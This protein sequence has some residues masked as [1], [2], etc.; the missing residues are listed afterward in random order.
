MHNEWFWHMHKLLQNDISFFLNKVQM[1]QTKMNLNLI[2][3]VYSH[4]STLN[5]KDEYIINNQ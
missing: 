2:L 3:P 5:V 1:E 4:I